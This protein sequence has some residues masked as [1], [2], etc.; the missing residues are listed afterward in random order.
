MDSYMLIVCGSHQERSA[1]I[2]E[3]VSF[4][5]TLVNCAGNGKVYDGTIRWELKRNAEQL[6]SNGEI[7][8]RKPDIIKRH[9]KHSAT[10]S[11]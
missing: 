9:L 10:E 5:P 4:F 3:T 7:A 6:I 1:K 8:Q 2:G 11:P